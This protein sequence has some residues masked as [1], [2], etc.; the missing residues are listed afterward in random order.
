MR[1]TIVAFLYIVTSAFIASP[2]YG[3]ARTPIGIG[4]A[5][6][7]LW[8]QWTNSPSGAI[9]SAEQS[10]WPPSHRWYK[11]KRQADYSTALP[12]YVCYAPN[13]LSCVPY[14]NYNPYTTNYWRNP[15]V[16]VSGP[17]E[18]AQWRNGYP[19]VTASPP[20][21]WLQWL[22]GYSQVTVSDLTEWPQ[23]L[24]KYIQPQTPMCN[25]KVDE[26]FRR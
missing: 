3:W 9:G 24:R 1:Q 2:A 6:H 22:P 25:L 26:A 23:W 5:P 15:Q 17:A 13:P 8:L 21:E 4:N 20:A 11:T 7:P 12:P 18:W 10:P 19:Q 16:T 14:W